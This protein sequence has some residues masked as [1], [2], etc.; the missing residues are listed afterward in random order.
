MAY[1]IEP[2]KVDAVAR[3]HTRGRYAIC[4]MCAEG[5]ADESMRAEYKRLGIGCWSPSRCSCMT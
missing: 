5:E 2:A 4:A 3:E 1:G